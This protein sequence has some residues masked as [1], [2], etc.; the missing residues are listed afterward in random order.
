[1]SGALY[2]NDFLSVSKKCGFL[3]P[4][5]VEDSPITVSNPRLE[6][7]IGHIKFFSATYRLFK[8]EDLEP[9]CEDYGQAVIYKGT[10]PHFPNHFDLDAHHHI[11]TGK[12]FPVCTNT[13][14]M[15][16]NTR[17]QKHFEFI[18]LDSK[19]HYGIFEGCGTS[20]PFKDSKTTAPAKM[21]GCC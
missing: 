17:F 20:I 13:L 9:S 15:L 11:E 10:I 18:N 7:L 6:I 12:V 4:R 1:M 19:T 14:S 5:L 2:W 16:K 3:D 8:L 21:G